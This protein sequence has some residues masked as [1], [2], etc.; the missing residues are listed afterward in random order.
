MQP[1][2][3]TQGPQL[4]PRPPAAEWPA[5]EAVMAFQ[6]QQNRPLVTHPAQGLG[7]S[8]GGDLLQQGR[9]FHPWVLID[10]SKPAG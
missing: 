10:P 5:V 2:F 4:E 6:L 1:V 8:T 9:M 3:L 7:A